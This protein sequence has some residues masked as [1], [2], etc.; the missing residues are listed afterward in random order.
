MNVIVPYNDEARQLIDSLGA[1][2]SVSDQK[3]LIREL[4]R[5]AVGIAP[6]QLEKLGNAVYKIAGGLALAL[7]EDYYDTKLGIT[8]EAKHSLLLV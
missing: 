5:Y 8:M 6:W 4:Q 7:N 1:S 3:Q 2:R